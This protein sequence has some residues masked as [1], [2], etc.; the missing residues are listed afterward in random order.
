[1]LKGAWLPDGAKSHAFELLWE[2]AGASRQVPKS[3]LI[4]TLA[5]YKVK[6]EIIASGVFADIR[7]G[8]LGG[9]VVTVKT[10]RTPRETTQK[11]DAIHEVRNMARCSLV[12]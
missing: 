11:I 7:K 5:R 3:Y 8:R 1:M 4:G 10:I 9:K 6:D 12:N 2:L